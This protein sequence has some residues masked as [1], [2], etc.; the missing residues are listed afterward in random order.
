[1]GYPILGGQNRIHLNAVLFLNA[2]FVTL[3]LCFVSL[4]QNKAADKNPW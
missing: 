2:V 4:M 3:M 1:M